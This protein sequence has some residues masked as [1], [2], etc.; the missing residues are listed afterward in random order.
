LPGRAAQ[1]RRDSGAERLQAH[2]R[3]LPGFTE[4]TV[5]PA[6]LRISVEDSKVATLLLVGPLPMRPE[7]IGGSLWQ[8][9][10]S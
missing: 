1:H 8:N 3:K 9:A 10:H 6:D 2:L 7:Y 4:V 5:A